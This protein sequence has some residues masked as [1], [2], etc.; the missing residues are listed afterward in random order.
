MR[1][2]TNPVNIVNERAFQK[3][4][5][6]FEGG[7]A[8]FIEHS[9]CICELFFPIPVTSSDTNSLDTNGRVAYTTQFSSDTAQS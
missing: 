1:Q 5:A 2:Y 4:L 9:L 6:Q 3:M 7:Q 8:L